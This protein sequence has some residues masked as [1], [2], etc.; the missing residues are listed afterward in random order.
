MI[1][2]LLKSGRILVHSCN[3]N[4][5]VTLENW[6]PSNSEEDIICIALVS[7][8]DMMFGTIAT[9]VSS[10]KCTINRPKLS[11]L[12]FGGLRSGYI[13]LLHGTGLSML[14][15][16]PA[17]YGCI[18]AMKSC[19]KTMMSSADLVSLGD[20]NILK[21]WMIHVNEN[22]NQYVITLKCIGSIHLEPH[23]CHFE[24]LGST[25][26]LVYE[27]KKVD[28]LDIEILKASS[29]VMEYRNIPVLTHQAEDDHVGMITSLASSLQLG[30]FATC[31]VDGHI[32]LWNKEN[33]M[34]TEIGLGH[35]LASVSF[36][37]DQ[38]ELVVGIQKDLYLVMPLD[39]LPP[40]YHHLVR[41][42]VDDRE[43]SRPFDSNVEFW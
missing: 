28:M 20:D 2:V 34:V 21:L 19:Q 11:S 16:Q 14:Y 7:L 17:H 30:L 29:S 10:L 38:G 26:C 4:P 12:L 3:T 25:L 37:S 32:K 9:R 5:C 41:G 13:T 15:Q 23:P 6:V 18:I 24:L 40:N 31:S 43:I 27:E 35:P 22:E 36:G 1:Y 8:Y 39:Y 42:K 33:N